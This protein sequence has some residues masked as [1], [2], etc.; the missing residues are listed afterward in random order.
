MTEKYTSERLARGLP[1]PAL[2]FIWYLWDTYNDPGMT[3]FRVTL[4][5]GDEADGQ[6]FVIHSA[7]TSFTQDFGCAIDADIAVRVAGERVFME[8]Y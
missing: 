4:Q 5:A 6:R 1:R 3:E 2:N 8:Y 7:G